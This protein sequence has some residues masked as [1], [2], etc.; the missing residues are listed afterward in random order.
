MSAFDDMIAAGMEDFESVTG[1]TAFTMDGK[2][3][4]GSLNEYEGEQEIDLDGVMGMYNATLLCQKPQFKM[5]AKPLH[6]TLNG[7]II[8]LD[9]INY[10]VD[11]VAVD[12]TSVT[13]GLRI[14]RG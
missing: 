9:S 3:Y 5:I 7:K 10:K 14:A 2:A 6:K 4:S 8:T 11:R 13:L 12:S 1:S